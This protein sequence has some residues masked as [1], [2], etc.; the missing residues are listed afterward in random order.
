MK[1]YTLAQRISKKEGGFHLGSAVNCKI[2][3]NQKTQSSRARCPVV[4]YI[5][6]SVQSFDVAYLGKQKSSLLFVIVSPF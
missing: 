4:K 1:L 6:V 3:L 5:L 2:G